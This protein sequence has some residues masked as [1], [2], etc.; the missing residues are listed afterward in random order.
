MEADVFGDRVASLPFSVQDSFCV[1]AC[2]HFQQGTVPCLCDICSAVTPLKH[3][4][5]SDILLQANKRGLRRGQEEAETFGLSFCV[6]M[7]VHVDTAS[8]DKASKQDGHLFG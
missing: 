7:C 8:A 2:V 6:V 4:F 3:D 1:H 5:L